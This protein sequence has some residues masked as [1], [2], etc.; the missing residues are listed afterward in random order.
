MEY[1][2]LGSGLL[3]VM[4]LRSVLIVIGVHK[5][6]ILRSFEKHGEIN[7]VT[8]CLSIIRTYFKSP[9]NITK[10]CMHILDS[11]WNF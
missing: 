1:A 10:L 3:L 7:I 9:S 5:D 8:L 6:P 2:F 11:K 4:V